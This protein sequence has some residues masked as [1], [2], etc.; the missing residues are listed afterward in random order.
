[1]VIGDLKL[2][3]WLWWIFVEMCDFRW[4]DYCFL[5]WDNQPYSVEI[6]IFSRDRTIEVFT[7]CDWYG[8]SFVPG[9][10]EC[11]S[12]HWSKLRLQDKQQSRK[13]NPIQRWHPV[14]FAEGDRRIGGT[15]PG[16]ENSLDRED[17]LGRAWGV[18]RNIIDRWDTTRKGELVRQGR[19]V[20]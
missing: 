2:W 4:D 1:M 7:V 15:S 16:Q 9:S 17:G 8:S 18:F 19:R 3:S 13:S 10:R 11:M 6:N 12:V 5:A 20:R 14:I